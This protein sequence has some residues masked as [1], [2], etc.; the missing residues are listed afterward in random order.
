MVTILSNVL[1]LLTSERSEEVPFLRGVRRGKRTVGS[2]PFR[3]VAPDKWLKEL[4]QSDEIRTEG[5]SV[6][7]A[8]TYS[9][10]A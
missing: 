5:P 9:F 1:I 6:Q 2:P 7:D 8:G 10:S 3:N 4:S